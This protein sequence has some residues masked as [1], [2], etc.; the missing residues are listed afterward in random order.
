MYRFHTSFPGA[1]AVSVAG[2]VAGAEVLV[3]GIAAGTE[4]G[5]EAGVALVQ[6]LAPPRHGTDL[7]PVSHK[8]IYIYV[9][10]GVVRTSVCPLGW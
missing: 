5:T 4:T 7:W 3:V 6:R 10:T 9:C 1:E 2:A 8:L